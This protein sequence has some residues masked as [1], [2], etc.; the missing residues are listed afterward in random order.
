[1]RPLGADVHEAGQG[2]LLDGRDEEGR[3]RDEGDAHQHRVGAGRDI[4]QHHPGRLCAA[5]RPQ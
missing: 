4:L 5:W 3:G 2:F 1:H